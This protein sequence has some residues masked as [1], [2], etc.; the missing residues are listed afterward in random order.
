MRSAAC[1]LATSS[2]CSD[3]VSVPIRVPSVFTSSRTAAMAA[4]RCWRSAASTSRCARRR[5]DHLTQP[6]GQPP[7]GVGNRGGHRGRV[8][9]RGAGLLGAQP[10]LPFRGGRAAQRIRPSANGIGALFGGPHRQ[11]GLHFD[12]ARGLGRRGDLL[13]FDGLGRD[14]LGLF[15]VA[16][17]GLQFAE[18]ADGFRAPGLQAPPVGAAACATRRRRRGRPGPAARVARRS[19]RWRHRTR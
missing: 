5:P 19:P 1:A 8:L 7:P 12:A 17:P 14:V 3:S 11:P 6:R 4:D 18:L 15:N 13:P 10:R 16:Q 2:R 9:A